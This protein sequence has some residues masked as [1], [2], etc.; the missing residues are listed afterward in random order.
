MYGLC[1]VI[2]MFYMVIMAILIG[3]N[4]SRSG[5]GSETK[6]T[7]ILYFVLYTYG[8]LDISVLNTKIELLV[9]CVDIHIVDNIM[10]C[11]PWQVRRVPDGGGV[12]V[13]GQ[14]RQQSGHRGRGGRE[15][16]RGQCLIIPYLISNIYRLSIFYNK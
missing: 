13:R 5:C 15:G 16:G 4:F 2:M 6:Y 1:Q 7:Y 8:S 14:L 3:T 12:R 10:K 11:T 9:K